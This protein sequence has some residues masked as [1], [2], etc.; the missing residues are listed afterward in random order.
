MTRA[1]IELRSTL[2]GQAASIDDD[3]CRVFQATAEFAGKKWTAAILLALSR[4]ATR[5]S[6][7]TD[8]VDGISARLLSVRLREL[9]ERDLLVREVIPTVPVQISYRLTDSGDE[10]IHILHPL[11]QWAQR[12]DSGRS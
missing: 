7:I 5:F 9:E 4:G 11:V 10:L 12:H 3:A 2:S 1:D 6:Q 8:A